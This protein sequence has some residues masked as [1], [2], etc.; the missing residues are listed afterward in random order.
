[1]Q[2]IYEFKMAATAT[3]RAS[4]RL[5]VVSLAAVVRREDDRPTV[6]RLAVPGILRECPKWMDIVYF[7]LRKDS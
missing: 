6:S 3:G 2:K 4:R 5:S 7:M 1:M